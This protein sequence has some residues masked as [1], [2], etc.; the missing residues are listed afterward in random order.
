MDFMVFS[1]CP[2]PDAFFRRTYCFHLQDS[3]LKMEAVYSS[4]MMV[5]SQKI[6]QH[7]NPEATICTCIAVET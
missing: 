6:T 4:G 7:K 2:V 1:V 5:Y 3:A